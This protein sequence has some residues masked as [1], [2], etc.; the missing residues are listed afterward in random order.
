M[1]RDRPNKLWTSYQGG[2][3]A[4]QANQIMNT[5]QASVGW[6]GGGE[7]T[8]GRYFCC[9]QWSIEATFWSLADMTGYA[10]ASVEPYVASPLT[11]SMVHFNGTTADQWFDHSTCQT[12]Q[13]TDEF[14]DLEL[15]VVHHHLLCECGCPLSVDLLAGVRFFRFRDNLVWGADS[16]IYD[17]WAYFRDQTENNLMGGQIGFNVQ[18]RLCHCLSLFVTP[19]FG[20]FDNYVTNDFRA[21][22]NAGGT[23][24]NGYQT[25]YPG[26]CY[27]VESH[28][29]IFSVLS[30]I[31][32]G[33]DWQ[34]TQRLSAR[35]GYRVVA[36]TGVGLADNQIPPYL[37]DIPAIQDIDRNGSLLVHGAFA[38][39]TYC[40]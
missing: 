32:V 5:Q 30:Q 26:L 28:G 20:I 38:G 21:N 22:M 1:T 7:I 3:F 2:S 17:T 14:D 24:Y 31:D 19:K 36:I 27:P 33:L 16:N 8:F 11:S 10:S 40:F 9:N 39:M 29:N 15:N 18:Y 12:L 4:N 35:V 37:N 25:I 6:E 34:I 23:S 13:R